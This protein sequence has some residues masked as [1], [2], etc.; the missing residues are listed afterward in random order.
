MD[1]PLPGTLL[2]DE[3]MDAGTKEQNLAQLRHTQQFLSY[4]DAINIQ[5]TSV[6]QRFPGPKPRLA[7]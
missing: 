6:G 5:F 3:V 2:L 1:T 4:H 7:W